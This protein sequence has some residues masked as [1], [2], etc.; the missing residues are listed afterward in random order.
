MKHRTPRSMAALALITSSILAAQAVP[1]PTGALPPPITSP[2]SPSE[3]VTTA[4][5]GDWVAIDPADLLVM[6]VSP[7]AQGRARRV[8]IQMIPAPFAQGWVGNIRALAAA[9]WWDG[10]SINRVQDNYVVQWGDADGE[11]AAKARQLPAGLAVVTEA[12]YEV[13]FHD[14]SLNVSPYN[15]GAPNFS[16]PISDAYG[17]SEFYNGWPVGSMFIGT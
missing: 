11:D 7:D 8:V 6:D 9:H 4:P 13:D 10:L 15:P 12:N 16:G 3:I 2:M 14:Q 17:H 1:P 5:A